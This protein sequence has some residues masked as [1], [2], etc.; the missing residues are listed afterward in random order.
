MLGEPLFHPLA[1]VKAVLTTQFPVLH[2]AF[3]A[4]LLSFATTLVLAQEPD[5][6]REQWT[7]ALRDHE[8]V[9]A[10]AKY[11]I[12]YEFD[13]RIKA[14]PATGNPDAGQRLV[15]EK[16]AFEAN[17]TLPAWMAL[18]PAVKGYPETV[19]EA[20]AR[21]EAACKKA[22]VAYTKALQF[23][24]AEAARAELKTHLGKPIYYEST[25]PKET[26]LQPATAVQPVK[27]LI[28][29]NAKVFKSHHYLFI[30]DKKTWQQAKQACED[31]GG[32]LVTITSKEENDFVYK[33][34]SG[35]NTWIGCTDQE[36]EGEWKWVTGETFSYKNWADG[37]PD[38]FDPDPFGFFWEKTPSRWGDVSDRFFGPLSYIC[39]WER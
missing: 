10:N 25:V 5:L 6:I 33:L 16:K 26:K 37:Q 23:D 31:M 15:A 39:E 32:H 1:A 19:A 34:T 29:T 38:N 4:L 9:V 14:M 11:I 7:Q 22:E 13:T 2:P 8:A 30:P 28:P 18:V 36:K 21:L 12:T 27:M 20:G 17:G 35:K 24:K 3:F